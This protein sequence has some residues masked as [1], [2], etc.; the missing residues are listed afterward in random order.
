MARRLYDAWAAGAPAGSND[1]PVVGAPVNVEMDVPI[2]AKDRIPLEGD[3]L[4]DYLAREQQRREAE[5]EAAAHERALLEGDTDSEESEDEG[6]AA[7][8]GNILATG[9]DVYVKDATRSGGFFKQSQSFRM[10]PVSDYRRRVDDY[11]EVIDPSVYMRGEYQYASQQAVEESGDAVPMDL[12]KI[13][14]EEDKTPS[15]FVTY[16]KVLEVRCQVVFIDFEG[17]SDGKFIKHVLP[18][19]APRKLILVHG[20]EDATEELAN[21]CLET[22]NMTNEVYAPNVGE[23][24]NVSAATDIYQVKLTDSLVSSLKTAKVPSEI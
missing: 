21:Y 9:Y 10:F 5:A 6:E 13:R 4:A 14:P 12:D 3:E 2:T 11:G 18:Q 23:C 17:R 20:S 1:S 19:V 16:E 7:E 22:E 24:I 15:K 8:V